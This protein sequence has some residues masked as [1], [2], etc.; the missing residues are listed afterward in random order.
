MDAQTITALAQT[1]AA[2]QAL[3]PTAANTPP[4]TPPATPPT[5][6]PATPPAAPAK[7]KR[8]PKA[9]APE[10]PPAAPATPPA[11]LPP[12]HPTWFQ[13]A[14]EQLR[15]EIPPDAAKHIPTT[16]WEAMIAARAAKLAELAAADAADESRAYRHHPPTVSATS[17]NG[18]GLPT[19]L[20]TIGRTTGLAYAESTPAVV[21]CAAWQQNGKVSFSRSVR[22]YQQQRPGRTGA[23]PAPVTIGGISSSS[24]AAPEPDKFRNV[25]F[26]DLLKP[27]HVNWYVQN[28]EGEAAR[29]VTAEEFR[30][31]LVQHNASFRNDL[32]AARNA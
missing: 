19:Q 20:L 6:P 25:R 5:T 21:L 4:A 26:I 11:A 27:E 23:E 14:E 1:L 30:A 24:T 22:L 12:K 29:R 2:L 15:K 10:T 8:T 31:A 16:T 32:T 7:K 13:Q 9:S 28:A 18:D 17:L 3:L